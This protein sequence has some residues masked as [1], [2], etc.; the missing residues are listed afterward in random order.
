MTYSRWFTD[1]NKKTLKPLGP[2]A[3]VGRFSPN[4]SLRPPSP[5]FK[6][7]AIAAA[8]CGRFDR[9]VPGGWHRVAQGKDM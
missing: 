3:A 7:D 5:N 2:R 8:G 9:F 1:K 6:D 4:A